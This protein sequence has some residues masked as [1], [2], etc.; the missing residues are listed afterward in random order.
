MDKMNQ[1]E[2]IR[3]KLEASAS[4]VSPDRCVFGTMVF[5]T[6]I[7]GICSC[8]VARSGCAIWGV[9]CLRT[10]SQNHLWNKD[11]KDR[12]DWSFL[13]RNGFTNAVTQAKWRELCSSLRNFWRSFNSTRCVP[14]DMNLPNRPK[15]VI[16]SKKPCRR[17]VDECCMCICR[18]LRTTG[19]AHLY[20]ET[21]A[22]ALAV[23][24]VAAVLQQKQQDKEKATQQPQPATTSG[25]ERD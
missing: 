18:P 16:L 24:A 2:R 5:G 3:E 19:A 12:K 1:N 4:R 14:E 9:P 11:R 8:C 7:C 13:I 23:A 15:P 20:R 21:K 10:D 25:S 17:N 6:D 22:A